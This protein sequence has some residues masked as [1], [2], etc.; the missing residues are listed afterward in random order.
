M[1][2]RRSRRWLMRRFHLTFRHVIDTKFDH[3]SLFVLEMNRREIGN[4]WGKE[5][6]REKL[7]RRLVNTWNLTL[8]R[9]FI[10][11]THVS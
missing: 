4:T 10:Y 1:K 8:S 7:L 11:W 9:S 3:G 6:Y 5:L 2:T